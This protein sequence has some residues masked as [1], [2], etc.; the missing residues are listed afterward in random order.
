MQTLESERLILRSFTE[1]DTDD[2]FRYAVDPDVGPRAGW[3]PHATRAESLAIVRMF[4]ADDNVWA[5]ERKSDH[6]MIGSLGLHTDKWRNLPDVRT[7]GYVLAKDCWGHG[8][9]T[10]AVRCATKY[11][12]TEAG[13]NMISVAHYTFN[14]RS[15]RVIEK[16]GFVYEGTLRRAFVRYDGEIFDEAIYSL[17]KE[18][19]L[20]MQAGTDK[21]V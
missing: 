14:D 11:A 12:F 6:R 5:I 10:E 1:L 2:L 4:I 3:K 16:C 15:R 21:P 7:I 8:Y 9:M 17:A 13:M 18:E 20:A 19:W